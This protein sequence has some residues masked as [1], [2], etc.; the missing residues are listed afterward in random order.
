MV[1]REGQ[2]L[3]ES[4]L[5]VH[6]MGTNWRKVSLTEK[7]GE[8]EGTPKLKPPVLLLCL[9]LVLPIGICFH[10]KQMKTSLFSC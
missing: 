5:P 7:L 6:H 4:R 3:Q 1:R 2:K 8:S 10:L 9:L